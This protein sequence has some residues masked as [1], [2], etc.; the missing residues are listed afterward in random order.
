MAITNSFVS[1]LFVVY[2]FFVCYKIIIIIIIDSCFFFSLTLSLCIYSVSGFLIVDSL[3]TETFCSANLAAPIDY[4]LYT[5]LLV[6]NV[7]FVKSIQLCCC[8]CFVNAGIHS[9]IQHAQ[10]QQQIK[11]YKIK[12][13]SNKPVRI[14]SFLSSYCFVFMTFIGLKIMS[15]VKIQSDQ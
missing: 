5:N 1:I 14:L 8:C 11:N 13:I 6:D 9:N 2:T 12:I 3:K 15:P 7:H 10:R 4:I